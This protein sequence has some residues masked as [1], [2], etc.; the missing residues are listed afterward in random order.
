MLPTVTCE[1]ASG[2]AGGAGHAGESPR[3]S[4]ASAGGEVWQRRFFSILSR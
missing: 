3:G 2:S 4:P 1:E